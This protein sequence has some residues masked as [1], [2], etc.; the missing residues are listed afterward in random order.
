M[1]F[2]CHWGLE[3]RETRRESSC[4]SQWVTET[5]WDKTQISS[6]WYSNSLT[7]DLEAGKWRISK[8]GT[9]NYWDVC[10]RGSENV[11]GRMNEWINATH[12]SDL[13]YCLKSSLEPRLINIT[14]KEMQSQGCEK[15][16]INC[17][18]SCV[19]KKRL[20]VRLFVWPLTFASVG[21]LVTGVITVG[22][23]STHK[24]VHE[25]QRACALLM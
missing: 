20:L 23:L 9:C 11:A 18:I 3:R 1:S 13:S 6:H 4:E 2:S 24:G 15:N 12:A 19:I 17:E 22:W 21:H 5:R 25:Q 16:A 7:P 10:E 14:E 8:Q